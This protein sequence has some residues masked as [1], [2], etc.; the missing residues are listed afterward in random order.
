VRPVAGPD[1]IKDQFRD[2]PSRHP[3]FAATDVV[4]G[5]LCGQYLF[6]GYLM[7]S[8]GFEQTI[9]GVYDET[10]ISVEADLPHATYAGLSDLAA[11]RITSCLAEQIRNAIQPDIVLLVVRFDKWETYPAPRAS[12]RKP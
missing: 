9:K 7:S 4:W 5:F 3:L 6:D 2:Y 10:H 8:L 12:E 1:R 11:T